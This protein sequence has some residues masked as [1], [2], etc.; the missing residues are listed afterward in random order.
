MVICSTSSSIPASITVLMAMAARSF[1][2]W[3]LWSDSESQALEQQIHAI[4]F[5]NIEF[6]WQDYCRANGLDPVRSLPPGKWRNCKC[7]VQAI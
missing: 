3:S 4:L 6:V 7:D 2:D 5:P 1:W